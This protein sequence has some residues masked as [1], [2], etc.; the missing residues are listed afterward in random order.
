MKR[1]SLWKFFILIGFLC[2]T[3]WPQSSNVLH[4]AFLFVSFQA[5]WLIDHLLLYSV[6]FGFLSLLFK[7]QYDCMHSLAQDGSIEF[8]LDFKGYYHIYCFCQRRWCLGWLCNFIPTS[9]CKSYVWRLYPVSI[10]NGFI[11]LVNVRDFMPFY[12]NLEDTGRTVP[13]R[14]IYAL[15]D[16]V[17]LLLVLLPLYMSYVFCRV[18]WPGVIVWYPFLGYYTL[19]RFKI[20]CIVINACD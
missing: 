15:F 10:F 1:A 12:N 16:T 14:A 18:I 3:C 17:N 20:F 4:F 9:M 5:S 2:L 11:P 7:L 19:V 6:I 13:F 8:I